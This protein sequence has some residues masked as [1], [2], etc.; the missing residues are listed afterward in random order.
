[1]Y[2]DIG[3]L[4]FPRLVK[5]TDAVLGTELLTV[6]DVPGVWGV[7]HVKRTEEVIV[8]AHRQESQHVQGFGCASPG[9]PIYRRGGLPSKIGPVSVEREGVSEDSDL[10]NQ[11]SRDVERAPVLRFQL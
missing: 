1:M 11:A 9:S 6:L 8:L 4:V 7:G 10:P 3:L 5:R 2:S